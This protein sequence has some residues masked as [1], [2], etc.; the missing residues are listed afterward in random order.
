MQPVIQ[1]QKPKGYRSYQRQSAKQDKILRKERPKG[2]D[3][4]IKQL[5][6]ELYKDKEYLEKLL[7]ETGA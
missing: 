7:E 1:K 5:L 3:K 6:G 4:S 2:N